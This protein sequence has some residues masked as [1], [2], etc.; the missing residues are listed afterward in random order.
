MSETSERRELLM[1][2]FWKLIGNDNNN[3]GSIP[4][5]MIFLPGTRL[6]V[7]GFGW[8]PLTWM[9]HQEEPY[10]YPL[11]APRYPTKLHH[12]K[13]LEVHCPGFILHASKE[14]L[15][16]LIEKQLIITP[17][18][19]ETR[20]FNL[21]VSRGLHEWYRV[22]DADTSNTSSAQ[23]LVEDDLAQRLKESGSQPL[24]FGII[25]SRP[26][27]VESPGEIGLLVELQKPRSQDMF[28]CR[29]I[30][31]VEVSLI[32]PG[33]IGGFSHD[34]IISADQKGLHILQRYTEF[35]RTKIIGEAVADNQ[36]WCVDGYIPKPQKDGS[37]GTGSDHP[38]HTSKNSGTKFSLPVPCRKAWSK[39]TRGR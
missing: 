20:S 17:E 15:S 12:G 36:A 30:R 32:P 11:S 29:I 2:E 25:L 22:T 31:R 35:G 34:S 19:G 5:G 24:R 39:L 8:A 9:A 14:G 16:R 38:R 21:V 7:P 28:Y 3:D 26:R 13:G 10:P 33:G 1:A 6:S 18:P 4:S 23:D 37:S 27:P